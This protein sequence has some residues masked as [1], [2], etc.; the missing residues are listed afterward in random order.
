MPEPVKL[1]RP[2]AGIDFR[3]ARML[4][5]N[6]PVE[7]HRATFGLLVKRED[8]ACPPPGPP[9]SKTRGV[10]AHVASRPEAVI[11][12]LDTYHSQAGHAVAR[13]CQILGKTCI[14][15]YPEFKGEPGHRVPQER[16]KELGAT[17]VGLPAG[18]SAVLYHQA[19]K[20]C[21][22]RGGYMMPNALKLS[23]SVEETAKE[24]P[25]WDAPGGVVRNVLIP[26]SS[27][28]IA[29]GVIRGYC[30]MGSIPRFLIHLGYSRSHEEVLRYL[31]DASGVAAS[32]LEL[33]LVDENY[34]YKDRAADGPTPLWPC[35]AYYDLKALRWWVR[36]GRRLYADDRSGLPS[37]LW[38]I[39]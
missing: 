16:A 2:T 38:N 17:L 7:D 32:D 14:N 13:A 36:E 11:G 27:G 15:Y 12:A 34:A 26:A 1:P 19:K 39:G 6:T 31:S 4:K 8:L 24:V 23:E 35:N 5:A 25:R 28:T 33:V 22:K 20:D 21:V 18:R 10:Y 29:A 30:E 9:F 3:K 37:L